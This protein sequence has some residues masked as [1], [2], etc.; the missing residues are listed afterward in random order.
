MLETLVSGT[1]LGTTLGTTPSVV[2]SVVPNN[3]KRN[4]LTLKTN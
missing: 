3:K 4:L 2:P 1:T